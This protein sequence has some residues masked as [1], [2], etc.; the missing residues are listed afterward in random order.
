MRERLKQLKE[1]I[2]DYAIYS[3]CLHNQIHVVDITENQLGIDVVDCI[4]FTND[5][6]YWE[7][8][9]KCIDYMDY[10]VA[11]VYCRDITKKSDCV[12]KSITFVVMRDYDI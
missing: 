4:Y 8:F 10:Y 2:F 1:V 5:I 7:E 9:L 12:S 3:E 11:R 6:E